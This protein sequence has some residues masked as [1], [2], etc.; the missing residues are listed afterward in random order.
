ME[1]KPIR[2]KH[3]EEAPEI[4]ALDQPNSADSGWK[5]TPKVDIAPCDTAIIR[6]AAATTI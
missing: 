3:N 2:K 1:R 5:K 6:K 4:V